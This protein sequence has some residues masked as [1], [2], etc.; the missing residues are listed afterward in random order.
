MASRTYAVI[1]PDGA[2]LTFEFGGAPR[3]EPTNVSQ[4]RLGGG[5][6]SRAYV[7]GKRGR[8]EGVLK[9]SLRSGTNVDRIKVYGKDVVIAQGEGTAAATFRGDYHDLTTM[10]SGPRPPT[11]RI[12]E[13]FNGLRIEDSPN[14]MRVDVKGSRMID[15]LGWV[16][17]MMVPH[18]G[19]VHASNPARAT[20][21]LP[22]HAGQRTR[23][24]EIW[25]TPLADR[26]RHTRPR[27]FSYLVGSSS[28][29]AEV[30]LDPFGSAVSDADLLDWLDHIK[31]S[32]S[33]F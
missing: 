9:Y 21:L 1:A 28:G 18:H 17:V 6:L 5:N 24:G 23:H 32:I 15:S 29:L 16:S 10:F 14:G 22:P 3:D 33:G 30:F 19:A 2:S 8:H 13:I 20:A 26:S 12:S 31:I 4:L 25:R 11:S 27:D 7:I